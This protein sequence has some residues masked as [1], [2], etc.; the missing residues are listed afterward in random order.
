MLTT[1][2][3]PPGAER[4]YMRDVPGLFA[5]AL[6]P[7]LPKGTPSVLLYLQKEATNRKLAWKWCGINNNFPVSLTE[8]DLRELN[9]SVWR[10][11]PPLELLPDTGEGPQRL[12][13]PLP[14]P[15]W[16]KYTDAFSASPPKGWRLIPVWRNRV[17]E[18]QMMNHEAR[19]E[20]RRLLGQQ[21]TMGQLYAR[22][23]VSG[24]PT[25]HLVGRQLMDAFLTVAEFTEFAH[26]F[27]VEVRVI[28]ASL[29]ASVGY[30]FPDA[31]PEPDEAPP[32]ADWKMR[33]QAEAAAHWLSLRKLHCNP[34]KHGILPHL[35]KW[36][37]ENNIRTAGPS[38]IHPSEGYLKNVLVRWQ[39]PR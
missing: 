11:L 16:A 14:E 39:P 31:A 17:L 19:N 7:E 26:G 2:Y 38:G 1:I 18:Q 5:D 30:G 35:A 12:A 25:P 27:E 33:V 28:D 10:Q 20:W 9:G 36:C 21:S 37:R 23:E 29:R 3:L 8:Q 24:I 6:H 32:L 34:T 22:P 15:E 4:V 13:T